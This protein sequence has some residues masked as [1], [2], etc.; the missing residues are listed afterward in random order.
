MTPIF[1]KGNKQ[2]IKKIFEKIVFNCLYSYLNENSLL[3][4]NQSGFRSGDSTTNQLLYL[5]NE[6]HHAFE[7]HNSL[8]VRAVFLDITKAFDKVWNAGFIF[9]LEQNGV[10]DNLLKFF[11]N[12]LTNRKQRVVLNGSFSD[13]SIVESG[14]PQG[15]VLGPLLFLTLKGISNLISSSSQMTTAVVYDPSILAN[16]LN[17]DLNIILQWAYHW[18]MEF[19]PDPSNQANEVLFS[20]KKSTQNHPQLI[21]NRSVV[22]KV[23]NQKHFGLILDS[24][25][26]FEKH[27][28]EKILKA[29]KNV[30][31]LKYLSNF[32]PLKSLDQ[33]Y[34]V[35]SHLDYCDVIYHL[36][37]LLH[38]APLGVSLT[39]IMEI[40]ERVQYQ[41]GLAITGAWNGS[42]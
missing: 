1:K 22:A 31:V 15:S 36:P 13:Y 10:C 38:Q 19:N 4:R 11:Q 30:V 8:E 26:S 25:L 20:C 41:A 29:K 3:T 21:I 7:N 42:S 5:V 6:I 12:Y 28:N 9:K 23:S 17:H 16:D 18:K 34:N 37:T 33:M 24:G 35:R 27:L 32:L 2:L 14:V 39:S 40:V